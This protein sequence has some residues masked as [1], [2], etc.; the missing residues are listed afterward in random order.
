[1][2]TSHAFIAAAMLGAL[3]LAGCTTFTP[4]TPTAE[5][6]LP[7]DMLLAA[8]NSE[9]TQQGTLITSDYFYNENSRTWWIGLQPF[10]AHPGCNPACVVNADT[11]QAEIN[12]RCTGLITPAT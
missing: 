2:K 10:E 1:M 5:G 12:W 8:Q 4:P 11:K 6:Q 9:C 3:I 7:A